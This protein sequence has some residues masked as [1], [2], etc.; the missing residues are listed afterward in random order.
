MG[1]KGFTLVELLA[2]IV[3]LAMIMLIAFPAIGNITGKV[4]QSMLDEKIELIEEA[5]ILYGQN[6]KGRL[7]TNADNLKYKGYNCI[8]ISVS[9]LVPNY[10]DADSEDENCK[11]TSSCVVDPTNKNNYLDNL[12]VIIYY[13]NKRIRAKV[14]IDNN[15][16]CKS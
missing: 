11:N 16:S 8:R 12:E 10:L 5:A 13:K 3:L 4:N 1:K 9:A 14:D 6:S 7:I 2:V 15:L